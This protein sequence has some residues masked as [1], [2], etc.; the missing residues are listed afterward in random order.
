[1]VVKQEVRGLRRG[2]GELCGLPVSRHHQD[3][4][5]PLRQRGGNAAQEGLHPVPDAWRVP[6]HEE[7][8]SSAVGDKEGWHTGFAGFW[9]GLGE[10]VVAERGGFAHVG[11]NVVVDHGRARF[12]AKDLQDDGAGAFAK[13]LA[14]GAFGSSFVAGEPGPSGH[15]RGS[16]E[17]HEYGAPEHCV[18]LDVP[19]GR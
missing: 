7:A 3:R 19:R 14:L 9:F 17:A 10:S 2:D 4:S 6:L 11:V 1:M 8:R 16:F 5:G 12:A 18:H 15:C 13:L